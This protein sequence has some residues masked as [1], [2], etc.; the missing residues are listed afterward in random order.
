MIIGH[1]RLERL[2]RR[3][4]AESQRRETIR[5]VIKRGLD[6]ALEPLASQAVFEKY[7]ERPILLADRLD[8][9][10][11][12]RFCSVGVSAIP[13]DAHTGFLERIIETLRENAVLCGVGKE[14]GSVVATEAFAAAQV[15][16]QADGNATRA[17]ETFTDLG[18][19]GK[20]RR[21]ARDWP[22]LEWER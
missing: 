17:Q 15:V 18:C 13:E 16:D 14:A 3:H 12:E 10:F 8:Q 11:V 19:S 2:D 22:A 20:M 5:L 21:C 6:L 9:L 1:A 4:F 7:R